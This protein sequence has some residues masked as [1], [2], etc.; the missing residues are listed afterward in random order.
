MSTT[1]PIADMLT[2]IRNANMARHEQVNIPASKLKLKIAKILKEERFI[3]GYDLIKDN[4]Q[5]IIKLYLGYGPGKE[6]IMTGLKRV[7]KP[8]LR[9]YSKAGEIPKIRGG[10]GVS[11]LSTPQGVMTGKQ[12]RR[13]RVGG[14]V[15]CYV[16]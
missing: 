11:I 10:L 12:A 1:D 3:K 6:R 4:K 14:E 7:S 9:I 2:R 8:G 13:A 5:G 16:W 15:I